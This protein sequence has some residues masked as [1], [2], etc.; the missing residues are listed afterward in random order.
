M[1]T[2][3]ITVQSTVPK[4]DRFDFFLKIISLLAFVAKSSFLVIH[5]VGMLTTLYCLKLQIS[6]IEK[7]TTSIIFQSTM[8]NANLL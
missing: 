6:K 2:G 8:N 7:S 3:K 1:L 4:Y 5:K